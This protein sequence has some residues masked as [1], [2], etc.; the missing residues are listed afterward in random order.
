MLAAMNKIPDE[1]FYAKE[2][3]LPPVFQPWLGIKGFRE[4]LS[5]SAGRTLVSPD[6]L[7]VLWHLA[8]QASRTEYSKEQAA[9]EFW[10]M[11]VYQGG[12]A[13][14]LAQVAQ[15][16]MMPMRLFDTF[17]GMPPT[18]PDRDLHGAG[19]FNNT[20]LEA[21]RDFVGTYPQYHKGFIPDTFLGLESIRI[22]F[23]HIDVDIY[24]SVLDCCAFCYPRMARGG[25][26]VFDDYGFP[27]C[28]GAR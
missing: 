27:S 17:T 2:S 11:G 8:M 3:Q 16:A 1:E 4:A 24:Q 25:F 19:D 13:R 28:P 6:R 10:E 5:L 18:N 15:R 14:M 7:W 21:V 23:A 22:A 9:V 12:T 20:S 26:M